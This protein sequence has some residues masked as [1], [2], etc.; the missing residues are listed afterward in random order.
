MKVPLSWLREYIDITV[1]TA[2][3]IERLTMAGLEVSG[4]RI[5]GLPIPE[6]VSI[7]AEDAGPVWDREK[8]VVAQV[9]GVEKHP[10]ADKLT[11]VDLDYGGGRTKRVVT[12]APNLKVG[13]RGQK[14]VLGQTGASYFDGHATP[15]VLRNL[16]P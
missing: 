4:V 1:P 16:E 14:V 3:L 12:G 6:G 15:K 5:I 10:N 7:K 13:D 11:L 9:K 2:Q 8:I